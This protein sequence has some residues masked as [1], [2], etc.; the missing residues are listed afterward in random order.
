MK[1]DATENDELNLRRAFEIAGLARQHGNHPFGALLAGPAG[2]ILMETENTVVTS[3]DLTAHAERSLLSEASQRFDRVTLRGSTLYASTEPCSMCATA[4]RW[5]G[6]GRIVFGLSQAGLRNV[7][8]GGPPKPPNDY[9]CREMFS[10][11]ERAISV[12]GPLLEDEAAAVHE[13]FWTS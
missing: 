2:E 7:G 11:S 4:A 9:S 3:G 8:N 5:V 6:V 13:G 12:I 1:S 10:H